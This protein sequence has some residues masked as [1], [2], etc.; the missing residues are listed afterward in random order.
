M[1]RD[2]LHELLEI[3]GEVMLVDIGANP[4]DGDAPYKN[5]LRYGTCQ[6]VG[7]EPQEAALK[8]LLLK[9][10]SNETYLPYA[11][12]DGQK[13]NLYVCKASGMTSTLK[14]SIDNLALFSDFNLFGSVEEVIEIQTHR[15]DEIQEIERMDYLKIDIQ[16]G[17]L[18]VFRNSP[19]HMGTAVMVHTEVSFMPLYE[20]QPLIGDIDCELRKMGFVPHAFAA[21]KPWPIAPM[22]VNGDS[23]RALNQ[24]LEGDLIYVRDFTLDANMTSDQWKRLAYLAHTLYGSY[25]LTVRSI[26]ACEHLHALPKGTSEHYVKNIHSYK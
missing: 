9:K 17:E 18:D 19:R 23:R 14:P 13:K 1:N 20:N 22:I 6:L 8:E 12:G 2:A 3:D 10:G 25:D 4:I 11:V 26:L 15:L 16:G 21:L 24:L 7:F 5:A